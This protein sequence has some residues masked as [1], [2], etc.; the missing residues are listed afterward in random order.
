MLGSMM[1]G[2]LI[3]PSEAAHPVPQG[4]Y[5]QTCQRVTVRPH[6]M[7]ALCG[8]IDGGY[9]YTTLPG[10]RSCS[11]EI[12]NR[13]GHLVC[14]AIRYTPSQVYTYTPQPS[15]SYLHTC[16]DI[17]LTGPGLTATCQTRSGHWVQSRL[18]RFSDCR[19]DIA[20]INGF[21]TCMR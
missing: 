11:G 14:E 7:Q 17:M 2:M 15:G 1:L 16:T 4:S 21:L 19:G 20:N 5:I 9:R 10:W 13:N 8:T 12:V 18:P 3:Q 6:R